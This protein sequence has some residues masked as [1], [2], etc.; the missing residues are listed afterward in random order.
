LGFLHEELTH[1]V[2]KFVFD[3]IKVKR[4]HSLG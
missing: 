3:V 4:V 2:G 1:G